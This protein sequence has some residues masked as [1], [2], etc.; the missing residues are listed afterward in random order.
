MRFNASKCQVF[1]ITNKRK[2][3]LA[4]FIIHGQVLEVVDSAK[5]HG[6]HLD[7]HHN[8]NTR[9]DAITKRANG[10][11]AFPSRNLSHCS[12]KVMVAA[13]TMFVFVH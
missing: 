12:Q 2:P 9:V 8:F 11:W 1:Q 3:I 6:V 4:T 10:T 5:Y 13:Y 7:T